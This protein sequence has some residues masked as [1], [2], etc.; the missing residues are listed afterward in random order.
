MNLAFFNVQ[1]WYRLKANAVTIIMTP[2][3]W[4]VVA[5]TLPAPNTLFITAWGLSP[6]DLK[7]LISRFRSLSRSPR[8]FSVVLRFMGHRHESLP[9][10]W[11]DEKRAY[12][13]NLYNIWHGQWRPD[14]IWDFDPDF[15]KLAN[16]TTRIHECVFER[17]C[18]I[19]PPRVYYLLISGRDQYGY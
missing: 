12:F 5:N 10:T 8:D 14:L 2:T 9:H 16:L 17:E 13:P 4:T 6:G 1:S 11:M 19:V 7:M 3:L 18:E 15:G